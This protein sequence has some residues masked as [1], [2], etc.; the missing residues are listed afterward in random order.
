MIAE[1]GVVGMKRVCRCCGGAVAACAAPTGGVRWYGV[2][3]AGGNDR[4]A[5]TWNGADAIATE[6]IVATPA[7]TQ[8]VRAFVAARVSG[9]Q[10]RRLTPLAGEGWGEGKQRRNRKQR[11]RR[12]SART[13]P[14]TIADCSGFRC[15]EGTRNPA[16]TSK[17]SAGDC[18]E[19]AQTPRGA[20]EFRPVRAGDAV[21]SA[22]LA[23]PREACAPRYQPPTRV[24]LRN[25]SMRSGS[26]RLA[27]RRAV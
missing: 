19:G 26:I 1:T 23:A 12:P 9:S 18:D 16:T 27:R 17:E 21:Q 13:A 3:G 20:Y 15:N 7:R 25:G 10:A 8:S 5:G 14:A 24:I 2:V 11:P 4:L 22:S 6:L